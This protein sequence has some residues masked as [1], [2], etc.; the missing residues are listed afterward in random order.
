[1]D[2][3]VTFSIG[4][5]STVV[6]IGVFEKFWKFSWIWENARMKPEVETTDQNILLIDF[7]LEIWYKPWIDETSKNSFNVSITLVVY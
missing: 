6:D 5:V 3:K 2:G 1:M 7:D 4:H